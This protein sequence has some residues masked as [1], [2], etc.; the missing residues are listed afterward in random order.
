[1]DHLSL[2]KKKGAMARWDRER[3]KYPALRRALTVSP[4]DLAAQHNDE[5]L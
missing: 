4:R 5:A 1:V 2:L 3:A